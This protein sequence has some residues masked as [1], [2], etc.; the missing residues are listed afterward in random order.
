M[1]R[2]L[3]VFAVTLLFAS[4]SKQNS[5]QYRPAQG[6]KQYGGTY[7]INMIR[8]NPNGLDPVIINSKLADD[9]ASQIYDQLISLDSNLNVEPE[10]ATRWELSPDGRTYTF[11]LRTDVFFQDNECFPSSEGRKFVASDVAYSLERAC[12]PATHTVA[13]WVFEDKVEGA[14][15]YFESRTD[16]TKTKVPHVSGFVIVDDSTFQIKL[17]KPYAPF[18]YYLVESCGDI[19]PHEAVEHYG[20]DFFQH[21]VGTGAFTFV[22]WTPDVEIVLVRN[23]HYWLHDAAGNQLPLLDGVQI[24]FIQDD[25]IQFNEFT[26][27]TFDECYPLPTENFPLIVNA[28]TKTLT[29][30]YDKFVLQHTPALSTWFLNFLTT[31]PPFDNPKVRQ[32]FSYAIDR[33]KIVRY[34]LKGQPYAAGTHGIVPPAFKKYAIDSV[35]GYTFDADKARKIFADAGYPDG[36]NFP[37]VTF[38]VYPDP[39]LMQ[40]AE[41][42]QNM[43]STTLNIKIELQIIQFSQLMDNAEAGKLG[44]WGTRWY[45]DYPDPENFLNLFYG[46]LV[47]KADNI[48]S[49]P[50]DTRFNDPVFND[51]YS[52]ALATTDEAKR[53]SLYIQAESEAMKNAPSIILFYEEHYRLL[54]PYVHSYPLD[55]MERIDLKW[56]WLG[57]H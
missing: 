34:V 10:L 30:D 21:P 51:I 2:L 20:K 3:A 23:P 11:Y 46:A 31:K 13:Y 50:N 45:G 56:V 12:D 53:N 44:F 52:R 35:Y 55:A 54:Q 18:I 14:N 43:L 8:G 5:H 37:Q 16:T 6:G 39:R 48:P 36:K 33:E 7:H 29:K 28:N 57:D 15:A 38:N 40:I 17:I 1:K 32:A 4:C 24:Q 49:Y 25:K 26:R 27:G 9:I 42:V 22:K 41:A 19:V 47:P